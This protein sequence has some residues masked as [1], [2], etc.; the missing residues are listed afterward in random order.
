MAVFAEFR[1][2]DQLM[3]WP[4]RLLVVCVMTPLTVE[5]QTRVPAADVT[6]LALRPKMRTGQSE[7][8]LVVVECCRL[9]CIERVTSITAMIELPLN[10]IR[11]RRGGIVLL[12]TTP[13]IRWKR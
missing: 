12:M 8:R 6:H 11:K 9:P 5:R 10:V 4:C 2:S 13:A 3:V 7:I 1:E